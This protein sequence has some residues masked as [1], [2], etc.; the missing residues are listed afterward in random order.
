MNN[1]RTTIVLLILVILAALW[2]SGR[3]T[4]LINTIMGKDTGTK[5]SGS[6]GARV[7]VKAGRNEK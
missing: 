4:L 3:L 6:I 5:P 1:P 7:A 2:T